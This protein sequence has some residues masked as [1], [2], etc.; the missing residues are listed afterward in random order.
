M[1]AMSAR[2]ASEPLPSTNSPTAATESRSGSPRTREVRIPG[3]RDTYK[4][5]EV[6]KRMGLRWDP[7]GHCWH[8]TITVRDSSLISQ[9][10]LGRVAA[11]RPL[12]AF[13][14][15]SLSS[16]APVPP[17]APPSPPTMPR[18][19]PRPGGD[20]AIR[21][22]G[23]RTSFEARLAFPS[24]QEHDEDATYGRFTY[25][26]VTSGLPDDDRDPSGNRDCG[27]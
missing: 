11:I 6:L 14:E 25:W 27:G 26:D 3:T 12:D 2:S 19:P 23:S 18:W 15:V 7:L 4:I 5:R 22:D 24:T 13:D 1:T 9:E 16:P 8:G 21:H 17:P 20:R 10:S